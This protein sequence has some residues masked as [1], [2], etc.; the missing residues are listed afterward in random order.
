TSNNLHTR[1]ESLV[2]ASNVMRIQLTATRPHVWGTALAME[3]VDR[4]RG[5]KEG[6]TLGHHGDE[7]RIFVQIT[8]VLDRVHPGFDRHTQAWAPKSV[9]HH[10]PTQGVRLLHQG[11]HLIFGERNVL[12]AVAWPGT[13]ATGSGAFDHVCPGTGHGAH[14]LLHLMNAIGDTRR[15]HRVENHTAVMPGRADAVTEAAGGR[16]DV[17]GEHQAWSGDQALFH[18]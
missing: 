4:E 2:Y 10:T 5:D 15:Q 1:L 16:D 3:D 17:H 12:G 8:A 18:R 14:H 7:F 6:A 13:G 11:P 9:T